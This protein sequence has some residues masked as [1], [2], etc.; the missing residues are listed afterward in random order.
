MADEVLHQ[1]LRHGTLDCPNVDGSVTAR[2]GDEASVGAP[3]DGKNRVRVAGEEEPAPT[4]RDVPDP[5]G[6]VLSRG[7]EHVAVGVE[8]GVVHQ[9][10]RAG[11]PV[12]ERLADAYSGL[13][14]P[15]I[16]A[17]VA[18]RRQQ[19]AVRGEHETLEL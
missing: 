11:W 8:F 15:E 12:R 13:G 10:S 4:A 16:R 2:I 19:A 9:S 6:A 3:R 14:I 7:G 1:L 5:S 18:R 17:P